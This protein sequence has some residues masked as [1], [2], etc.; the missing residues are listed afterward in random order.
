MDPVDLDDKIGAQEA[1]LKRAE[2]TLL[3]VEAQVQEVSARKAFAEIQTKRYEQLLIARSVSE[4]GAQAKQQELDITQASLAAV[5]ANLEASRQELI[6]ARADRDGLV[7]QRANLRLISPVDGIVTRR[8]ADPGTTVVAGQAVVEVVEP[9][10]I[11]INVRF[12]QQRAQGLSAQLSA[13]IVLRSRL[14]GCYAS[15]PM[16]TPLQKKYWPRWRLHKSH[17]YCRR[18]VNWQK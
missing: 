3:A 15:N 12:D 14:G 16:P 10:S 17:K 1:T 13:Q 8:D 9:G 2:A 6:R 11:W 7:R 4:E 18:L 5:R